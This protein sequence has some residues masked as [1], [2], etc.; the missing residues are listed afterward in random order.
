MAK[1]F[2]GEINLDVRDSKPDWAAFLADKA[3]RARRTCSSSSM[4]TPA[5]QPGRRS[6]GASRCRRSRSLAD[7]G[8][9]YTQWHTTALCS[10][11]RSTFLTGRNHHQNGFAQI[12]EGAQ[13]VPRLQLPHPARERDDRPRAARRRV[14]HLLD[15]QEP[16]RAGR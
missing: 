3:P 5:W 10:P 14:E 4:T 8:L 13:R 9:I 16:Q 7:N 6:A 11:T 12:A 15:R 1:Q 2:N